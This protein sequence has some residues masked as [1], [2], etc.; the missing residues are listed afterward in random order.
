MADKE[1][2]P[3]EDLDVIS[4]MSSEQGRRFVQRILNMAGTE[5]DT[6]DID[7]YRHANLAGRRGVGTTVSTIVQ[8]AT[9]DLYFKMKQE[10]LDE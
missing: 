1:K 10:H 9:I 2:L 4:V 3:Q 5:S 6:F 7:P 8:N